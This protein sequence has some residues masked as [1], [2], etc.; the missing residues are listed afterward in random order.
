MATVAKLIFD[1]SQ[2]GNPICKIWFDDAD[3]T[4]MSESKV[5]GIRSQ[6]AYAFF[7]SQG[8]SVETKESK[9]YTNII[10]PQFFTELFDNYK[11]NPNESLKAI[12]M[13]LNNGFN[14]FVNSLD[15]HKNGEAIIVSE[16]ELVEGLNS[17]FDE[18]YSLLN[19]I[20]EYILKS[21]LVPKAFKKMAKVIDSEDS[22]PAEI[23]EAQKFLK[24]ELVS[25]NIEYI[26]R[27]RLRLEK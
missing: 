11:V 17:F 18:K 6:V 5:L 15:F 16:G 10:T 1:I 21:K 23:I 2:N 14:N 8:T 20:K 9:G 3:I 26:S 22:K 27:N 13:M 4:K 12:G 24:E 7:I 19:H 25:A